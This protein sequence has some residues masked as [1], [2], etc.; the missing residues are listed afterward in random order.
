MLRPFQN[1]VEIKLYQRSP[2]LKMRRRI[3][4]YFQRRINF[5]STSIQNVETTLIR[6]WNVDWGYF[7]Q[8]LQL[9]NEPFQLSMTFLKHN[10]FSVDLM[11][12]GRE[13]QILGP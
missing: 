2:M 13:F 10:K 12:Y 6:R 1:N 7:L 4:F 9:Q 11:W 8:T 5:I 3:L